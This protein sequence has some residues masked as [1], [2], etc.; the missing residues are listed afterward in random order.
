MLLETLD[1][2]RYTPRVYLMSEG[3]ALSANK[4]IAFEKSRQVH[5][6]LGCVKR[7]V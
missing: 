2:Q 4:A 7:D 5:S 6:L 3:D 1:F